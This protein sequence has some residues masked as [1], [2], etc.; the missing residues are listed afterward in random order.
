MSF[1]GLDLFIY[2]GNSALGMAGIF[3]VKCGFSLFYEIIQCGFSL[4]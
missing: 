4:L 3:E 2:G 1:L